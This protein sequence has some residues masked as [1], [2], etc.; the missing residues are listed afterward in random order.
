MSIFIAFEANTNSIYNCQDTFK[1]CK[2]K[3]E[4][5]NKGLWNKK[6]ILCFETRGTVPSAGANINKDGEETIETIQL[7][8]VLQGKKVTLIKMD[9]EGS[10]YNALLGSEQTIKKWHPRLTICVYHKPEDILEILT[11]LL[12]FQPDYHFAL[13]TY[14]ADGIET[15]LYA[16]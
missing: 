9:I 15:V 8:D 2:L 13:R 12:N 14:R 4:I 10:E 1:R 16:Y 6:D 7:D 11:L 5:I 3:G